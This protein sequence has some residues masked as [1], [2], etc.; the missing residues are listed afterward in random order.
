MV[1]KNKSGQAALSPDI[2]IYPGSFDPVTLG[3]MDIVRRALK[4]CKR[5]IIA[6]GYNSEKRTMFSVD[7]RIEL[8]KTAVGSEYN[9]REDPARIEIISFGGLLTDFAAA[10][11]AGVI[12]KGLR[13]ATDF[14]FEYQMDFANK[15]LDGR[16]ETVFVMAEARYSRLSS[17]LVKEIANYGGRLEGLVPENIA[18][19]IRLKVKEMRRE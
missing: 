17:S 5:L 18:D 11:G 13:S 12:I 16:L 8:L 19:T 1:E 4:I 9:M 14:E 2:Y 7:E 3:H 10:N 6:V 15:N